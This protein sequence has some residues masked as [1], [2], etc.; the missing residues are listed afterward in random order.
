MFTFE[1]NQ[2]IERSLQEV[3]DYVSDPA[4][5]SK[6]RDSVVV[7]EWT[8]GQPHG[9]GSTQRWVDKFLGREIESNVEIT[10]WEPPSR[11]GYKMLSG[12]VPFESTMT[13]EVVDGGTQVNIHGQAEF[14]GV[15]K[16]AEGLVRNQMEKLITSEFKN[17]KQVMEASQ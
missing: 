8:S 11:F 9:A 15:F 6:W 7:A 3:F 10:H 14:G 12:P 4:N 5:D 1:I 2:F 17:L 13:F 16:L